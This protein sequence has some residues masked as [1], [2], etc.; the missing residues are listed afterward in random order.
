MALSVQARVRFQDP[1]VI[2]SSSGSSSRELNERDSGGPPRRGPQRQCVCSVRL[3]PQLAGARDGPASRKRADRHF[4]GRRR[5]ASH[6]S[7]LDGE[8]KRKP[9]N[10][11]HFLLLALMLCCLALEKDYMLRYRTFGSHQLLIHSHSFI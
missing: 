8:Q 3:C 2:R 7:H 10:F 11:F 4:G 1:A 9:C 6:I 5:F